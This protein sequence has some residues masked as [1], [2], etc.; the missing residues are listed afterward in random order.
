MEGKKKKKARR[1]KDIIWDASSASSSSQQQ[2]DDV[3]TSK[4][5][6]KKSKKDGAEDNKTPQGESS[7]SSTSPK[8]SKREFRRLSRSLGENGGMTLPARRSDG[9]KYVATSFEF[10]HQMEREASV[11]SAKK[12]SSSS[13]SKDDPPPLPKK[14]SNTTW[15]SDPK[16]SGIIGKSHRLRRLSGPGKLSFYKII[17]NFFCRLFVWG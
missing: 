14:R 7:L 4:Q 10:W 8:M 2:Q 15:E 1:T 11:P 3:D 12:K 17:F 6:K 5:K 9:R 13:S 16:A